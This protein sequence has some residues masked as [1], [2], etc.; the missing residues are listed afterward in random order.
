LLD[1]RIFT[2]ATIYAIKGLLLEEVLMQLLKVS[3]YSAVENPNRDDTLSVGS[4]GM[5]VKG[6]G[7]KHQIAG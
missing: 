7:S 6:R 3:G 5:E 4:S 1:K 2:L